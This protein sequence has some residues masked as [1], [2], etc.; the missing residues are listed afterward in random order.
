M[1]V[2]GYDGV[3]ALSENFPHAPLVELMAEL[4]WVSTPPTAEESVDITADLGFDGE[5]EPTHR[6]FGQK[7]A[8]LGY[9]RSERLVPQGYP[10]PSG[11]ATI[12][13]SSAESEDEAVL[14]QIGPGV[15]TVN[16]I[17]PYRSWEHFRP[18]F[19]L[20]LQTLLA[21]WSRRPERFTRV[22]LRYIDAFGEDFL[23]GQPREKFLSDTLGFHLGVPQA[24]GA[25][26]DG[27]DKNVFVQ[28]SSGLANGGRISVRAG[29][30]TVENGDAVVMD[31]T[32]TFKDGASVDE[33]AVLTLL[34]SAHEVINDTFVQTTK[35]VE[36]IMRGDEA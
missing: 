32:V 13:F 34:D 21:S 25:H 33:G 5:S 28:F 17:P 20:G 30:A 23:R 16:A 10:A 22:T 11:M 35:G 31:T 18:K 26:L 8:E 6:V 19:I 12:S 7:L 1:Y 15:M 3:H 14:F 24:F 27:K 2:W 29:D 36:H 9:S 4:R